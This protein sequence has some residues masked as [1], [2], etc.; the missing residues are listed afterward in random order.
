M[1]Q[2]RAETENIH[3]REITFHDEWA[4]STDEAKVSVIESFESPLAV[5]TRFAMSLLGDIT[6]KSLLEIGCGLGEAATYFALRGAHVIANDISPQMVQVAQ[7]T[8]IAHN[9]EIDTLV[10]PAEKLD[11]PDNSVDI[12]YAAN[13][14]PHVTNHE[15]VLSEIHRVL[16][17]GGVL[18][19]WDP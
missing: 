9:V 3:R 15:Q 6:G 17:T 18:I 5:E 13:L 7:R 4:M 8:A 2:T 1:R 14:L 19:T 10:G 11:L 16:K 12:C